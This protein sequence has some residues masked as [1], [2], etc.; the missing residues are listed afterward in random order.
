MNRF[1][2]YKEY[3]AKYEMMIKDVAS[4]S[5]SMPQW[6]TYHRGLEA[7]ASSL[8]SVNSQADQSRKS[9]TIQDL[10]VKVRQKHVKGRARYTNASLSRYN[11]CASIPYSSPNSSSSR[12]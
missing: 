10:L 3:G 8:G 6:E 2:I 11:G 7:L 1:F 5:R 9:L 4:A 12:L